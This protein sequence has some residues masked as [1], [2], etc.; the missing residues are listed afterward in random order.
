MVY[1]RRK[2]SLDDLPDAFEALRKPARQCKV[3]RG[4][5]SPGYDAGFA[6]LQ[7]LEFCRRY[8]VFLQRQ[9]KVNKRL[10]DGLVG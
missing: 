7:H 4:A 6:G 1:K 10:V 5:S 9:G 8:L 2:I 3:G